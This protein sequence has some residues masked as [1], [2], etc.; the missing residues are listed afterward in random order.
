MTFSEVGEF[1]K[2]V[3][4]QKLVESDLGQV[5]YEGYVLR[6][7]LLN[8]AFGSRLLFASYSGAQEKKSNKA[9]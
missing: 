7:N 2:N 8:Q 6:L 4:K 5:T 1:V 9:C 3:W